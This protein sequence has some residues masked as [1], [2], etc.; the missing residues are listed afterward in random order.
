MGKCQDNRNNDLSHL[1]ERVTMGAVKG[2]GHGAKNNARDV[3]NV[4][5]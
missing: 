5:S 1:T 3:N 2:E 4:I